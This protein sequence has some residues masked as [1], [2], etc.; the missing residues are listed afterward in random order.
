MW[1]LGRRAARV[2]PWLALAYPVAVAGFAFVV[3]RSLV[4]FVLRRDVSW[5][6]RMVAIR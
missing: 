5:K 1:V 6:G 3:A 4:L 2:S